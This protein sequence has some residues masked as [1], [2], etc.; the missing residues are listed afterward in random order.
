MTRLD[1]LDLKARACPSS[2]LKAQKKLKPETQLSH[3]ISLP[4]SLPNVSTWSSLVEGDEGLNFA[5]LSNNFV[6]KLSLLFC[7]FV[8]TTAY[9]LDR[10]DNISLHLHVL[11]CCMVSRK[12]YQGT[13]R[14]SSY[15]HC[16]R[17]LGTPHANFFVHISLIRRPK[18]TTL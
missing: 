13:L 17:T 6:Q 9:R 5:Q 8:N 18:C 14:L 4:L 12:Q 11:K 1:H 7:N 10:A 2:K 15:F 16:T 3:F